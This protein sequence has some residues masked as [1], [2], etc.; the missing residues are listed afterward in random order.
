MEL[1]SVEC[2]QRARARREAEVAFAGV[3]GFEGALH[4]TWVSARGQG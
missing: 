3:E 1:I 2:R 4:H